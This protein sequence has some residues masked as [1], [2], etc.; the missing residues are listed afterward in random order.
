MMPFERFLLLFLQERVRS[1]QTLWAWKISLWSA[2][3][4]SDGSYAFRKFQSKYPYHFEDFVSD[5][6]ESTQ[7]VAY[8]FAKRQS[9]LMHQGMSEKRSFE[10]VEKEFLAER[11]AINSRLFVKSDD[12]EKSLDKKLSDKDKSAYQY[13]NVSRLKGT[14]RVIPVMR[15]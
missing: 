10:R 13:M 3:L 11:D 12:K 5:N 8:N 7:Y 14:E 1:F 4:Y 6:P 15:S 9:A 2:F